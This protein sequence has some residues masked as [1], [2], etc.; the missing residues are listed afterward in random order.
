MTLLQKTSTRRQAT[1]FLYGCEHIETIRNQY[2]PVQA[3]LIHPHVTLC[4]EDEVVNWDCLK[5]KAER[6]CPF[7][8]NVQFG[9]PVREGD[10]VYLPM[11]ENA[12]AFDK[13]RHELLT[14]D[15]LAPR[16]HVAHLTLIHPR[17]GRCTDELFDDLWMMLQPFEATFSEI[18]LI[19][20]SDGGPWNCFARYGSAYINSYNE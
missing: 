18:A 13:L 11:T 5:C 15:G 7:E 1:L 12:L 16:Q 4:R 9:K 10:L 19:E 8:L 3:A 6:A 2:N 14:E 20:Q 17:N